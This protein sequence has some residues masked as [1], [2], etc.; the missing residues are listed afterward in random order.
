ML[1]STITEKSSYVIELCSQFI[2]E[3]DSEKQMHGI[4]NETDLTG[5]PVKN[6][7]KKHPELL[8]KIETIIERDWQGY[9]DILTHET[10]ELSALYHATREHNVSEIGMGR[11]FFSRHKH[12]INPVQ[13]RIFR[14]SPLLKYI[15]QLVATIAIAVFIER[16]SIKVVDETH[17]AFS[18]GN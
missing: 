15:E 4:L 2:Q 14:R 7:I 11:K 6:L 10:F 1:K 5:Y 12:L 13:F 17:T 18:N 3:I 8:L 16:I 9:L